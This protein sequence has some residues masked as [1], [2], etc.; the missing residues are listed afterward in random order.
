MANMYKYIDKGQIVAFNHCKWSGQEI[1]DY[2]EVG[3]S[4]INDFLKKYR[5][6]GSYMRSQGSGRKRKIS[7]S[8]SNYML[9]SIKKNR[10]ITLNELKRSLP[11]NI[12]KSTISRTVH[13]TGKVKNI[14]QTRKPFVS[15]KNIRKRLSWCQEHQYWTV[16]HW[17]RVIW[18]DESPFVFRF[19]GKSQVWKLTSEK[20]HPS[21]LKGTVKHDGKIMVWGC[22]AYHG[23]GTL[24]LIPGIMDKHSYH[25]ILQKE[26]MASA[27]KLFPRGNYIFQHD[28]DP[29]HTSK[30]C[31]GYLR[32]KKIDV[33]DWP[34]QSP[35]LNPI[36]NLW[37]ILDKVMKERKPNTKDEL[38]KILKKGW[39][40]LKEGLLQ[41][42]VESMPKRCKEVINM[43]G[44][45]IKY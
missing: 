2:L 17:K 3:K 14:W 5:E 20:F 31:K 9:L 28:N 10:H 36:E 33:L 8:D 45:P 41:R 43:R 30:L 35:D 38:F 15:K 24:Q 44:Y 37:S 32:K 16:D 27:K 25:K 1:A 29:K 22:F 12:S 18:S 7:D 4:T 6:T 26:L 13:R 40:A 11:E 21:L 34:A 23:V 39:E 42:L 19:A